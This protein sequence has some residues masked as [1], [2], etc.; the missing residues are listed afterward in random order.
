MSIS[1]PDDQP[2][3]DAALAASVYIIVTGDQHFLSLELDRPLILTPR[4]FVETHGPT[5]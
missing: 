1:D 4:G 5:G 3:V 2:I